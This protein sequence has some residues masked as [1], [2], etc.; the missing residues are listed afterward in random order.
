MLFYSIFIFPFLFRYV[1][2]LGHLIHTFN[3]YFAD[4]ERAIATFYF[5]N[6]KINLQRILRHTQNINFCFICLYSCPYY[7]V[8]LL[9]PWSHSI[10]FFSRARSLFIISKP[11]MIALKYLVCCC[12]LDVSFFHLFQFIIFKLWNFYVMSSRTN[13][14]NDI[15]PRG[16]KYSEKFVGDFVLFLFFFLFCFFCNVWF[17]FNGFFVF[18]AF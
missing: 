1:R 10:A 11:S 5:K 2:W 4:N 13:K 14:W 15:N 7:S 18:L 6:M 3:E 9:G 12:V 17:C 16:V 8:Q